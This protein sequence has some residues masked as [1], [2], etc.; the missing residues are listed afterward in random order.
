MLL[1]GVDG[2]LRPPCAD[3][4]LLSERT[5]RGVS[6]LQRLCLQHT[7]GRA[8]NPSRRVLPRRRDQA[9]TQPRPPPSGDAGPWRCGVEQEEDV[10]KLPVAAAGYLLLHP[11]GSERDEPLRLHPQ[12]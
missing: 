11:A 4:P 6:A 5:P 10:V 9:E 1:T 12:A 2:L 3:S 7:R 8:P